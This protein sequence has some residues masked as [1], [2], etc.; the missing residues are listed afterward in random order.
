MLRKAQQ[1]GHLLEGEIFA[2]CDIDEVVR[3]IRSSKTREEAIEK[4]RD[5]RFQIPAD[6]PYAPQIPPALLERARS[7]G[8]ARLSRVQAEAI[9]R[10]Q[11]IQLVGLE[12]EKLTRDYRE[13][14]GQIEEYQRI[15]TDESAVGEI[16]RADTLEMKQKFGDKA[17]DDARRDRV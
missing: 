12:I 8:G 10:L 1:R 6:H 11:L 7:D 9:G 16:I 13:V 5:R 2:V 4:L 17:A 3:L 15:L 14:V